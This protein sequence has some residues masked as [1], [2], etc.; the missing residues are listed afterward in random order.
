MNEWIRKSIRLANSP[1]YLDK[2][3]EVYP[4][5]YEPTRPV[6]PQ[7]RDKLQELYNRRDDF[8]LIE[9]LL[10]L[11]KFPI[12]N[13][14]VAFL[15]KKKGSVNDNPQTVR[16]IARYL[17]SIGFDKMIEGIEEPKEFNRQIGTLLKRWLRTLGYPFLQEEDFDQCH[18]GMAFLE[19]DN[20]QLK[21]YA[22]R[23]LGCE[24]RKGPDLLARKGSLFIIGE[25][26]FLTDYGGHQL[27]Q[28]SDAMTFLDG[29]QRKALRIAILD[30]VVWIENKTRMHRE[31][32]EREEPVLS[33]VLLREFLNS[34]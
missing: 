29:R 12:K 32:R 9:H 5:T 27:G 28:F 31:V 14:Y 17:Y 4:V 7:T 25:G 16:E 6:D 19:G 34:F 23:A 30:G 18:E 20:G 8:G 1:G 24:L 15:R 26:K 33:A 3:H 2:L 13:P 10:S 11:E 21:E 22:N